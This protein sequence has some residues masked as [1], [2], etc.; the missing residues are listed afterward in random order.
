MKSTMLL[1]AFIE[2]ELIIYK[3][4]SKKEYSLLIYVKLDDENL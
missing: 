1:K 4:N 2:I 3:A